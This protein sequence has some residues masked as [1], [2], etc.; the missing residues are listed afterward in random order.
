[1]EEAF[2]FLSGF[3]P[4]EGLSNS[5]TLTSVI[6]FTAGVGVGV[7]VGVGVGVSVGVGVGVSVGVGVG[8]SVGVGVGVSVGVGVGVGTSAVYVSEAFTVI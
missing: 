2:A 1:M 8:V 3:A 4:R 7:S 5:K 6:F